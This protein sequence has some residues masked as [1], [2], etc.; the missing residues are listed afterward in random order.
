[1]RGEEQVVDTPNSR[2]GRDGLDW[3]DI[4]GPAEAAGL[5]QI[6]ECLEVNDVGAAHQEE[7]SVQPD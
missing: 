7:H 5:D 6:N 2:L 1:M 3:K 4:D